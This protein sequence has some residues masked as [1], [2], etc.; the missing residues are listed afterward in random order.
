MPEDVLRFIRSERAGVLAV[1]MLNGSPHAATVHF[2]HTENPLVFYFET[3]R[4]YRKSE[5]LFGREVTRASFV[6]GLNEMDMKTFQLDGEVRLVKDTE[7]ALFNEA[8][9]GKFPE[10]L[11]KSQ[12]PNC[13]F[14]TFVPTWWR[15]TD[16]KTAQ[17]K[18]I[19]T[20]ELK[21]R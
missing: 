19:L 4:D 12:N 13:V 18:V 5:P 6:I 1:E 17:G 11:K 21:H 10:K 15:F 8:Y 9:F 3:D 20:S 2:A 16:W 7:K 14:F